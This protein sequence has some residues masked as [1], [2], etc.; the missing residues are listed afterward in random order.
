MDTAITQVA[1][2]IL[3]IGPVESAGPGRRGHHTSLT[4]PYLIIGKEQ[5]MVLEPGEDCQVAATVD[6]LKKC[7]VALDK[8]GY[9]W[10]SHIHLHHIQAVPDLMKQLPKAKF[11]VHPRGAPH[12]IEPTRLVA[13]SIEAWGDQ[14]YGPMAP[15]PKER[16]MSV[17]DNQIIDLGRK[18]IQVIYAPGHAPHHMGLFDLETRALFP[19]DIAMVPGPGRERGHH[20]IRPPLFDVDKFVASIE[21]YLSLKPS[22]LLTFGDR[23]GAVFSVEDSLRWAIEDHRAIERICAD[24][25]RRKQS[26]KE[27]SARV[28][29]YSTAVDSQPIGGRET[30]PEFTSGGLSG[31]IAYVH[32][33]DPS[34]ELPK[35][36]TRRMRGGA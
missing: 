13:S 35:D 32:R 25:M 14:C 16:V 15:L 30:G 31:M 26:F 29:E 21:H 23:G 17:E 24:G 19:G 33:K 9:I 18:Q 3:R 36:L 27:I 5:A 4:S 2:G 34:L 10:A 28:E 12:V 8:V 22:M 11:V 7:G 1:K 20:D 6:A